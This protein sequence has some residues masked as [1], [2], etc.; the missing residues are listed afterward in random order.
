ML[1]SIYPLTTGVV[2]PISGYFSDKLTFRPLTIMGMGLMTL[3]YLLLSVLSPTTPIGW[4]GVFICVLG[5]STGLFQSPNTSSVMGAV[6]RNQVGSAGSISAFF[7]NFGMVTGTAFA[8]LLYT[9]FTK[10]GFE[11]MKGSGFDPLLFMIG[12]KGVM[13]VAAGV[14]LVGFIISMQ[15]KDKV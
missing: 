13:R 15:R 5:L 3:S 4:I 14:T 6:Q 11:S 1:M 10:A 9:V 7:R 12:F 2:A 8:I